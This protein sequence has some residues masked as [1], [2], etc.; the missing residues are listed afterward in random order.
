MSFP[1]NSPKPLAS[2]SAK[3]KGASQKFVASHVLIAFVDCLDDS[4]LV[5]ERID[6]WVKRAGRLPCIS[7]SSSPP[8]LIRINFFSHICLY[9]S[10]ADILNTRSLGSLLQSLIYS[11][12]LSSIAPT[13][14]ILYLVDNLCLSYLHDCQKGVM[15]TTSS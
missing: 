13:R 10:S 7:Y 5:L 14:S 8:L 12:G 6:S 11:P 2:D 15:G 4:L 1:R 9:G 3:K